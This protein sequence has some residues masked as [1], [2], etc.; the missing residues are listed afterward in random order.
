M[1]S[2]V[3][4]IFLE[5][6]VLRRV[7]YAAYTQRFVCLCLSSILHGSPFPVEGGFFFDA[8]VVKEMEKNKRFIKNYCASLETQ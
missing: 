6:A 3:I 8:K 5:F 7:T 1:A 2:F 4:L